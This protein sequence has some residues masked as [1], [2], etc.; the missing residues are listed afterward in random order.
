MTTD[1]AKVEDGLT[2]SSTLSEETGHPGKDIRVCIATLYET[3]L[4]KGGFPQRNQ[5]SSILASE[6]KRI[7][8]DFEAILARL[9]YWNQF[10]KP[11]LTPRDLERATSNNMAKDYRYGCG[12]LVLQAFCIDPK[13]CPFNLYVKSK[14]R[15]YNDL[16]FI[17][18]GW[19][20]YLSNRQVL[21]YAVSLPHLEKTRQIN[22][23]GLICAN[24]RQ[25][26]DA[27][28][29]SPGRI[30]HDLKLLATVGLIEYNVGRPRKWEG[31][32][33]EIRRIFPIP[34]PTR[35]TINLIQGFKND[36]SSN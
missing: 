33:S 29:V 25:V 36:M 15:N 10:N 20:K 34:R 12:N 4:I 16:K 22:R 19:P 8:L 32:A 6:F 17:D 13:S 5:V 23:G 1:M 35:I 28:G 31:I 18:F 7:G 2:A 11:P 3:P 14:K 21:I 26:A 9:E 30:G 24:H 27:C